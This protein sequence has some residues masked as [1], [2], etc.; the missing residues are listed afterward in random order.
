M[1]KFNKYD[2]D[3]SFGLFRY[4]KTPCHPLIFYL[5]LPF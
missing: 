2:I 3:K 5:A 4:F 1:S